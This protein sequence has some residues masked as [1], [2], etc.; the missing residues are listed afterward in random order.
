MR[1]PVPLISRSFVWAEFPHSIKT[2]GCFCLP[3]CSSTAS[4]KFSQPCPAWEFA[5]CARTVSTVF[6]RRTPRFAHFSR[7]SPGILQAT[8]Q[9][10]RT[11]AGLIGISSSITKLVYCIF[12]SCL[13]SLLKCLCTNCFIRGPFCCSLCNILIHFLLC[14]TFKSFIG[15]LHS[16]IICFT[17]VLDLF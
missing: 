6:R 3:S 13:R 11:L 16:K 2:I 15:G 4:V 8:H 17:I 7:L 12:A 1:C 10:N 14:L 5:S 9:T